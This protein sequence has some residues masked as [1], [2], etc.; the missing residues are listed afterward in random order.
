VITRHNPLR[1]A[2]AS[3]FTGDYSAKGRF[4]GVSAGAS[5]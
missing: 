2:D 4:K 1:C 5:T 3:L